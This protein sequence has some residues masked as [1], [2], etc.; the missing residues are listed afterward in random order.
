MLEQIHEYI[1]GIFEKRLDAMSITGSMPRYNAPDELLEENVQG[2]ID[3]TNDWVTNAADNNIPDEI[4]AASKKSNLLMSM[5]R[6]NHS[7][8]RNRLDQVAEYL[9]YTD[10]AL[11]ESDPEDF[12]DT[13]GF[14][15]ANIKRVD[16]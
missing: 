12:E 7:A 3:T 4:I 2:I 9:N 8:Q 5:A 10:K 11:Y 15:G 6:D 16:L 14:L 1:S 13:D